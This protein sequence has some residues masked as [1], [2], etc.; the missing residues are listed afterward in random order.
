MVYYNVIGYLYLN[1][2]WGLCHICML[3]FNSF[4]KKGQKSVAYLEKSNMSRIIK[5]AGWPG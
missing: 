3:P 1:E 4:L 2:F 5:S